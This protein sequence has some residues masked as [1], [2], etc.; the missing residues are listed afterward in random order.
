[1]STGTVTSEVRSLPVY[2]DRFSPDHACFRSCGCVS[3]AEARGVQVGD[4]LAQLKNNILLQTASLAPRPEPGAPGTSRLGR[5]AATRHRLPGR[6]A[7]HLHKDA[8]LDAAFSGLGCILGVGIDDVQLL[9]AHEAAAK[10]RK[11]GRSAGVGTQRSS[12]PQNRARPL[13]PHSVVFPGRSAS[14]AP[15]PGSP[16]CSPRPVSPPLPA[17]D[18]LQRHGRTC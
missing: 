13:P 17:V 16:A 1:M 4:N 15:A 2:C 3:R 10:T 9:P 12:W 5:A 7:P 8:S 11:A 6:S 14:F 18:R